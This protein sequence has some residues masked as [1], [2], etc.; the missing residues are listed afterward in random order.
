LPLES[1]VPGGKIDSQDEQ[2]IESASSSHKQIHM[3][4]AVHSHAARANQVVCLRA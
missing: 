2:D 3:K 4:R 1:V